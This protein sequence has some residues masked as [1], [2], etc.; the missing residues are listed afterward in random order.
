[1]NV[2]Q[3]RDRR[4]GSDPDAGDRVP[5]DPPDL[6]EV[7]DWIDVPAV[8]LSDEQLADVLDAELQVQAD[9]CDTDPYDAGLRL[10]MFRRCARA[11]AARGLPLGTLPVQMTGYPDAYGAQIIPRLDAE[12]ER[13]EAARRVIAV[14]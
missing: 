7:R 14:A 5:A 9:F 1:V 2:L 3:D 10:A 4:A 6:A 8:E 13:Y 12:I 11:N